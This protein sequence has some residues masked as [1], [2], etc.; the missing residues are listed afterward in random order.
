[1]ERQKFNPEQVTIRLQTFNY[2]Y[3][4]KGTTLKIYL[5]LLCYLKI[6]FA[7]DKVKMTSH[8]RY[9]LKFLPLEFNFLIYGLVLYL[10]TWFQWT[11][12]NKGI[13]ILIGLIVIQFVI[14]FIKI[15]SM[16]SIIHNWIEK[17]SMTL[18]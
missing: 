5:P 16:R 3:E 18:K 12:L 17:D 7:T 4:L 8:I 13:F 11:T 14:S 9:G 15:E 2:N 1:M 6:N 10:L